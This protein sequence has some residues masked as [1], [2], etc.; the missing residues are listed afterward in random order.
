MSKT[1]RESTGSRDHRLPLGTRPPPRLED[2]QALFEGNRLVLPFHHFPEKCGKRALGIPGGKS[3]SPDFPRN[4]NSTF[5][6][7]VQLA[8]HGLQCDPH[9]IGRGSAVGLAIMKEVK[10]G[11]I[12]PV[13]VGGA[14]VAIYTGGIYRSGDL[15]LV[16][17]RGYR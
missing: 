14:V 17:E 9:V 7:P 3:G 13:L 10:E 15:D 4:Q 1:P 2:N 5:L 16:P 6:E 12:D 11:G 8:L